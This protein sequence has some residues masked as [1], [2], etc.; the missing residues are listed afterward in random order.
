VEAQ[1]SLIAEVENAIASGSA[2]RRI[3]TLRRVTDL[4]MVN[5][6]LYSEAQVE[7][8]DDV[9]AR[10]ADRIEV[11]ARAEL[12]NRLAP[13]AN[14]PVTVVRALARD[15]AI[16][17]AGPVLE[18]SSRLADED[19]LAC[20]DGDRQDRLF[21]ISRRASISEA[22][23]DVL[24]ERGDREVVRSVARNDGARFSNGGF[25]KL[26]ERSADDDELAVSV[27]LRKDISR[28]HFRAL[29][30][31]ASE[32]VFKKIAAGNPAVAG[33]VNRVLFDLTG[34]NVEASAPVVRDYA[35][36][37]ATV[38]EL[39][40]SG[41]SIEEAVQAF[42]STGKF[43]ETVVVL[44]NLCRLPIEAVEHILSERQADG[45]IVLLLI[46]A[47]DM[48]WPTAKL[49]LEMRG[50]LSRQ[51]VETA[52]KHFERLQPTTAQRVVRFYQVR[53]ASGEKA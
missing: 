37:Q 11:K 5:V 2:D 36:A 19:L 20:A 28:D 46:K 40:Q 21:A 9:I 50:S 16:E 13:V 35:A 47:A 49:I 6:R 38:D 32:A 14:A 29:I 33:E 27:G 43:E 23:S 4:F 8:F 51:A 34:H 31:K 26:V 10:L 12:A 17:V 30:S 45:D 7:I 39:K 44:A 48:T 15:E 41:Q 3:E 22:V 42:A 1:R 52:R 53:H 18:H 24:V 25:G